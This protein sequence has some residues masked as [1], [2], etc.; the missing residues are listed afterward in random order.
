L[1]FERKEVKMKKEKKGNE[2][3]SG[4]FVKSMVDKFR[5]TTTNDSVNFYIPYRRMIDKNTL[6]LKNGGFA[7]IFEIVNQDLDYADDID[8]ILEYLN[9]TLKEVGSGVVL[10]YETQK[11]PITREEE[12]I[13]EFSP[14]PTVIGHK[15]RSSLFTKRRFYEIRHYLTI[16]Y[17]YDYNKE[18]SLDEALFNDGTLG[19]QD[20]MKQFNDLIKEFN[21]KVEDILFRLDYAVLRI[22]ILENG[23]LLNFLY[24]TINPLTS[25]VN[26]RVPPLGFSIDE[27]LSC[28]QMEIKNGM[29]KV[30][31]YYTKVVSIKLFPD[32]VVPQIFSELEKLKFPFRSVTRL[33]GLSK[34]EAVTSIKNIEKYQFGKRYN[35]VQII[36]NA[37][38]AA[39]SNNPDSG[40]VNRIRKSYEAKYAREELEA[41]RVS[42]GYYTFSVI[43]SDKNPQKLEEKTDLVVRIINRHGFTCLDDKLNV[44]DAY[45]GA[46]PANIKQNIR[47]SPMNSESLGYM[48]PIS[49]VFEGLKWDERINAPNLFDT[50]SNDRIF[51]FNNKVD[52][53]VGHTLIIGPT[54]K[55]KSVMLG[56]IVLNFMKYES[57]YLDDRK[58]FQKSGS[59]VFIFDKG[60]SSKVLTMASGGKF[61][62]LDSENH[63]A[64]QPLR[65]IDKTRDLEFAMDWVMGLIE[66]EDE[67]LARDVENRKEVYDGLLSL[68]KMEEPKKRTI[69]NLVKLIQAPKLKEALRVYSQEGIYGSYF[70]NNDDVMEDANFMT[71]EM[72]KI[73]EKP[74][75]LLPV[76]E[77]L[78]HRIETEKLGKDIPTLVVL[79]EC[80]VFLRHERM[81][82]KIEEWLKVLRKAN[83][84]VVFAT[85][86]LSDIEKSS[87]ATTIKDACMTKIFL[88]NENALS[89]H[90]KIYEGYNLSQVAIATID[91]AYG[92]RQ[93]LYNSKYGTRLFE[94]NLSKLELAYVG[95]GD[96]ISKAM[97]EKLSNTYMEQYPE[98]E[99]K[100]EYLRSLNKAY[101]K[102]KYDEG[103]IDRSDLEFADSIIEK[104]S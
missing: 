1:I 41:N 42:Y 31:D 15:M 39:R 104:I 44:K 53:D 75:V 100:N 49:S 9:D 84:S 88:P 30:G 98:P 24:R 89:T 20:Y 43:I 17:L 4:K 92:Q 85:Q 63:M 46:M 60:A 103:K 97:I 36:L 102:Y 69:T 61:Y 79:D 19:K 34:E 77:Y 81:K 8:K 35:M 28:S 65:N 26:L 56:T 14:I 68:S 5:I 3:A 33:I 11:V 52:K 72:G 7:R 86:S 47:K 101:L 6:L 58:N 66:Q 25:R 21:R 99:R 38:N 55:G 67:H 83:A 18:K 23:E 78:F 45:F 29:L 16:S 48:L 51:H 94:L 2:T 87:I 74:K 95:A 70:D 64:F 54:G 80:W 22:Q 96:D 57:V 90:S 76:L 50:I 37:F 13:G 32:A 82:A 12:K 10:H 91:R 40:N 93:Y 71:F 62:D 27:W 73:M 59:Q